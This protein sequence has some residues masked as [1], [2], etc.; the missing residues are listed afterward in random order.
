MDIFGLKW[1]VMIGQIGNLLYIC[2]N[3]RPTPTLMYIS[4]YFSDKFIKMMICLFLSAAAFLGLATS[5][6]WTAQANYIKLIARCYAH[7]RQKKV[8]DIVSLFFGIFFAIFGTC[9]IWGNLISY[10]V[11]NQSNHPQKFNC[12]VYF[13]PLSKNHTDESEHVSDLTVRNTLLSP[14]Y[15]IINFIN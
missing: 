3:I 4:Q 14:I 5:P 2:A 9:G 13:D 8:A 11:L 1:T 7:H 15:L 12:G 10:L 6:L